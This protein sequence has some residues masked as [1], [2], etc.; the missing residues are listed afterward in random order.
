MTEPRHPN[1]PPRTLDRRAFLTA[2]AALAGSPA[3]LAGCARPQELVVGLHTFIGYEP[4]LLARE[5]GW[6]PP[7]VRIQ[8]GKG[9]SDTLAALR[10]DQIQAACLTL[11]ETMLIRDE[12]IPLRVVAILD[13]S[14]GVDVLIARPGIKTLAD[15]K[16]KRIG[17]EGSAVG[18]LLLNRILTEAKL[19]DQDV[20]ALDLPPD[21]HLSA[22]RDQAVDAVVTY[23]PTA[24]LLKREGGMRLV[25]SRQFP[26]MIFDVL[27]VR[28]DRLAG[29]EQAARDL[30]MG[31]FLGVEHIRINRQDAVHRIATR[32]SVFP[33]EI[34]RALAGVKL[35]DLSGTQ[36]YFQRN[37]PFH[38]AARRLGQF[39]AS[40]GLLRQSPALDDLVLASLLPMEMPAP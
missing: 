23:E 8:H 36:A 12:G 13:V 9:C 16:G 2:L 30:L 18:Q 38:E 35:P 40:Q 17:R 26:D 39:M 34:Q 37:S 14:A 3:L 25:D 4:I 7:Q 19:A 6:L 10:A 33:Q 5:F 27:T 29:R 21:Q 28:A 32:Q 11:D 20:E 24:S 1:P 31:H 15:L 22:W